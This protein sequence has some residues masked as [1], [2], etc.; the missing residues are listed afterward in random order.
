LRS[1]GGRRRVVAALSA[2]FLALVVGVLVAVPSASATT[3]PRRSR[4]ALHHSQTES[5]VSTTTVNTQRTFPPPVTRETST[6]LTLPR[7]HDTALSSR[8]PAR[9]VT[10][11][12]PR[13]S[14]RPRR[15]VHRR[16]RHL[17]RRRH[18]V[19][20]T[21]VAGVAVHHTA[22][23][24]SS[25]TTTT[26]AAAPTHRSP[27]SLRPRTRARPRRTAIAVPL[28]TTSARTRSTGSSLRPLLG[29]VLL[30][31]VAVAGVLLFNSGSRRRRLHPYQTVIPYRGRT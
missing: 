19:R 12:R 14:R 7:V 3:R 5:S 20:R 30:V 10:R 9:I 13:H 16:V 25:T 26:T 17:H 4:T 6:T 1:R 22:L 18:S 28:R 8:P 29:L 27:L 2:G 11:I 31:I 24:S 23:T 15:V 21:A